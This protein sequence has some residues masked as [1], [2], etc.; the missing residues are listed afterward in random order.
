MPVNI[1]ECVEEKRAQRI[2]VSRQRKARSFGRLRD[3]DKIVR[4]NL[5]FRHLG[6]LS[7]LLWPRNALAVHPFSRPRYGHGSNDGREF[8]GREVIFGHVM[9]ELHYKNLPIMGKISNPK[10]GRDRT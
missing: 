4:T 2:Y 10:M 7:H 3:E 8:F 5:S 9:S 1:H 6:D